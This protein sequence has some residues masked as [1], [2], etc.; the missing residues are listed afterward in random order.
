LEASALFIGKT[1]TTMA[2]KPGIVDTNILVYALDSDAPH[3]DEANL[4]PV[5]SGRA[6]PPYFCPDHRL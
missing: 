6:S 4:P 5:R 1:S 3:C 2:V